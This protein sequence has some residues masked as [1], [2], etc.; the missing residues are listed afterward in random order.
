VGN[1]YFLYD[2][3]Y[4]RRLLFF[5]STLPF[6]ANFFQ[7]LSSVSQKISNFALV[8]P[9]VKMSSIY[10]SM[11]VGVGHTPRVL[12]QGRKNSRRRTPGRIPLYSY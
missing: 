2:G 9:F 1:I 10:S 11:F 7:K 8:R 4:S 12:M 6:K 3:E 5:P